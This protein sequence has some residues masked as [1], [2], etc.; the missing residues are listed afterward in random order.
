MNLP[1]MIEPS[2]IS[3]TEWA[4][5]LE[6]RLI[7][8]PAS[9]KVKYERKYPVVQVSRVILGLHI[10]YL[11]DAIS[12]INL[13]GGN[14]REKLSDI[15]Q[16]H[17]GLITSLG[18]WRTSSFSLR[19]F[20]DHNRQKIDVVLLGSGL[21]SM[22]GEKDFALKFTEDIRQLLSSLD[23]PVEPILA[24]EKLKWYLDPLPKGHI[25]EIRQQ[26]KMM[27]M[28]RGSA[29]VVYPYGVAPQATWLNLFKNI[30]NQTSSCLVN[31]HLEPTTLS[32]DENHFISSAA[33]LAATLSHENFQGLSGVY[34]F[35]DPVAQT[36]ARI[37]S[38]YLQRYHDP[39]LMVAQVVS[40]DP[41]VSR[42]IAQSVISESIGAGAYSENPQ[43]DEQIPNSADLA[44]PG[45]ESEYLAARRT[46]TSLDLTPWGKTEARSGQE[47][48]RYMVD[49]KAASVLFRFPVAIRGG[50][51]GIET[52]QVAPVQEMGKPLTGIKAG[53]LYLGSFMD[54]GSPMTVPISLLN[55]HTLVAGTNG[56]GKTTT[57]FQILSQLWEKSIPFM[58][59][60]PAK[61][62]Y[63]SLIK[64]SFQDSLLIFTLGDESTS[65]FRL[66]PLEIFPGVRVETHISYVRA[67]FEAA[68]PTF[69]VLP[70]LIQESLHNLYQAKGW[71]LSDRARK[72]DPRIM[73]TLGELYTEI[74]RVTDGRGYSDKTVQD[75][76]A[77]ASGRIGSLLWGSKGR[78]LNT[79]R[80]LSLDVLMNTPTILELESL[81]DEEKALVMLFLLTA[82]REY[83]RVNRTKSDLQHVTLIEEAHRVMSATSHVGDRETQADT[84][85]AA[86]GMVSA[87]LSEVRAYGEGL[88][89]AEQ[90]P[91]RLAED[92]LKNTNLKI[93]HR[94]PGEDDRE[95]VGATMN[96]GEEQEAYLIKLKPG[97][98]AVFTEGFERPTFITVD[99]YRSAN[100][101]PEKATD[102]EVQAHMASFPERY[103]VTLFPFV[104]CQFCL[105]QCRYR[106]TITPVAYDA[107]AGTRFYGTYAAF[108]SKYQAGEEVQ[109]WVDLVVA[110]KAAVI[111]PELKKDIHAAYCYLAHNWPTDFTKAMSISF[112]QAFL[113]V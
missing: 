85:A 37:Y 87:T 64:A 82:V 2:F 7:L 51:P 92:A 106:D 50:I 75:I 47:R 16:R 49:A 57:C 66:N 68:L 31:L 80:S 19:Y 67:C 24:E 109:A 99:D 97:Q 40:E 6:N 105:K 26:E 45:E 21:V 95:S 28:V 98:A 93:I 11:P 78:M 70:S 86:V 10:P 44:L 41:Y 61:A 42:N 90:I 77:A 108:Q 100:Q 81:N 74:I 36:V 34:E 94:L 4:I 107:K 101:L 83:C 103:S 69:G 58:V 33:Q 65:P 39:F 23:Y 59:I 88:I 15:W 54:R 113:G 112:R 111:Q 43:S 84:A 18:K 1:Q 53:D 35:A 62:E 5:K 25:A 71:S 20:W 73:P 46:L 60:E 14:E 55:R 17:V 22:N 38:S 48:L 63:R 102:D 52:H 72:D 30:C 110:C 56:S 76:R 32:E 89:I 27:Q 79:R 12:S 8:I 104:P 91:T 3:E 13:T 9:L 96:M 29:Y